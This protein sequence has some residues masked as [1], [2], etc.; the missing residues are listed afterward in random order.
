[1]QAAGADAKGTKLCF[2]AAALLLAGALA[3]R[4]LPAARWTAPELAAGGAPQ[5]A[6][7]V[8][9]LSSRAGERADELAVL[10]RQEPA[11]EYL[12]AWRSLPEDCPQASEWLG[13]SAG[14][15]ATRTIARLQGGD[16][17]EALGALA[18][19]VALVRRTE[20]E[21][22]GLGASRSLDAERLAELLASWIAAR[23]ETG[24]QAPLLGEPAVAALLVWGRLMHEVEHA[25]FV[26]RDR[27]AA[28]RAQA[29][30]DAWLAAADGRRTRLAAALGERHPE[31]RDALLARRLTTA[32]LD[33]ASRR[34]AP[35]LDG[36]CGS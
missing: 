6:Q 34:F 28:T 27:G 19:V 9:M 7:P 18:L 16:D 36:E 24:A 14:Q 15:A 8:Q 5:L 3:L 20:W 13:T 21:P 11:A 33:A 4:A 22:D 35:E 1:M 26:L 17:A 10:M 2:A 12:A 32:L 25:P 31:L 30:M 23:G 29:R